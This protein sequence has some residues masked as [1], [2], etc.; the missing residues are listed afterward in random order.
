MSGNI[1]QLNEDLIKNNLKDLV[2]NSVEETLNALLDHEADELV[3]A[4]KYQRSAER[5]DIVP[6]IMIETLRLLRATS[7]FTSQ[8]SKVFRSR[9]PSSKDTVG[10][11]HPL[12]K[13]L[14]KCIWPASRSAVSKMSRRLSGVQRY[15]RGPSKTSTRRLMSTSKSG[16]CVPFQ[17][18]IPTF[19]WMASI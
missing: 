15:L 8:S 11:N 7:P 10:E 14:S 1:I 2:R 17:E 13:L 6:A 5:R 18:N 12:R 4:D 3:R 16:A 19:M 9:P